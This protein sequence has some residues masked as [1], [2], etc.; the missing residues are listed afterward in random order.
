LHFVK[1]RL[2]RIIHELESLEGGAVALIHPAKRRG[3]KS[4]SAEERHKVSE[5]MMKYWA[6]RRKK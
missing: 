1:Q 4:M 6:S 2:D 3:R 5:R